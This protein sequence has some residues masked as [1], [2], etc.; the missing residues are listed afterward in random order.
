MFQRLVGFLS[1]LR[2]W[3]C[4][5]LHCILWVFQLR[6]QGVCFGRKTIRASANSSARRPPKPEWV[7]KEVIRL[8]ALMV[9]DGCRKI[10]DVFNRLYGNKRKM[11]VG[12]TY[13]YNTI[14]QYEYDVWVLRRNIKNRKPRPMPKNV[15]WSL[16]LTQIK[17]VENRNHSLFGIIDS[18]IRACLTLRQMPDK[19]SIT[20]L[21][22]LC[23]TIEQYG[24]PK[25]VRT[26]D[27]HGCTNVAGGRT[28]G[29]TNEASP[30]Q[31]C[32]GCFSSGSGC[33]ASSI[34]ARKSA[35]RG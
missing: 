15:I 33:S 24:K 32:P 18:G 1:W 28:P 8:K 17:D 11:T 7:R 20:L 27:V 31:N 22:A 34:N 29:A 4:D 26:D 2:Q 25:T 13:V 30:S 23:D 35:V 3:L 5:F 9:H 6:R 16:D 21:R 12:K 10:A 14:K 19:L